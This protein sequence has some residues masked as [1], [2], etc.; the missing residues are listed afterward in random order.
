M[1][2]GKIQSILKEIDFEYMDWI[3]SDIGIRCRLIF[4]VLSI[5]SIN[6]LMANEDVLV[7]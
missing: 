4:G 3:L 6:A 1:V 2:N 7:E 5:D